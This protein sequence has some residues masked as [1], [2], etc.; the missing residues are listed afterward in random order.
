MVELWVLHIVSMRQT[1]DQSLIKILP[2]VKEVW[3]GHVLGMDRWTE[4]RADRQT[5]GGHSYTM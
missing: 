3:S 2:G 5:D 1:F 4:G